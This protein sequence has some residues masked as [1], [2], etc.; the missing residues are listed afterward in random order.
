MLRIENL[1]VGLGGADRKIFRQD[2]YYLCLS[3]RTEVASAKD[4]RENRRLVKKS[5]TK[6]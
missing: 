2:I 4:L 3:P 1:G 5:D 6:Q